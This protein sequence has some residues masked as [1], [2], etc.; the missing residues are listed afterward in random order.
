MKSDLWKLNHQLFTEFNNIL[1]KHKYIRRH[2][3][4]TSKYT[5]HT[6]EGLDQITT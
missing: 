1:S 4:H 2:L 3:D 5:I 6:I